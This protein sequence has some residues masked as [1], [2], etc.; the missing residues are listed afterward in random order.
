MHNRPLRP[1]API[2]AG[3]RR[4]ASSRVGLLGALCVTLSGCLPQGTEIRARDS[5]P[6]LDVS[7]AAAAPDRIV[8]IE[9]TGLDAD[10][11]PPNGANRDADLGTT[12]PAD[13]QDAVVAD[14]LPDGEPDAWP[15]TSDGCEI[16]LPYVRDLTDFYVLSDRWRVDPFGRIVALPLGDGLRNGAL[17]RHWSEAC[18]DMVATL[19]FMYREAQFPMLL[20]R[21]GG[22]PDF[23]WYGVG[24]YGF[25]R[26]FGTWA[27]G[28]ITPS[29]AVG[30]PDFVD[31][32]PDRLYTLQA[33]IV[34]DT[35]TGL[36]FEEGDL[37]PI[38]ITSGGLTEAPVPGPGRVGLLE[39][40]GVSAEFHGLWAEP[41]RRAGDGELACSGARVVAPNEIEL[42][43][44]PQQ[45][46][47]LR[48]TAGDA[49]GGLGHRLVHVG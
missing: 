28:G 1:H 21:V 23:A 36:L 46:S 9:S 41:I 13:V 7:D 48:V 12:G 30:E 6:G 8:P 38:A 19:T 42:T 27:G 3:G 31:L 43:M 32:E 25:D 34:D 26:S 35:I 4:R 29:M 20:A 44:V 47:R 33:L 2:S 22:P 5:V 40:G 14:V 15:P 45:E 16:D 17:L 11:A 37:Q 18:T 39:V 24:Y 49:A 10:V